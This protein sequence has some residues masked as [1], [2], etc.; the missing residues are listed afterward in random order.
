[1]GGEIESLP[2]AVTSLT[3]GAEGCWGTG[4]LGATE[5]VQFNINLDWVIQIVEATK[6]PQAVTIG[7]AQTKKS[8]QY[9]IRIL[10]DYALDENGRYAE[11]PGPD[12]KVYSC[13]AMRFVPSKQ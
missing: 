12:Q 11:Q 2:L 6:H 8:G 4:D 1:L 10:E 9:L 5:S 7:I 3:A 13:R